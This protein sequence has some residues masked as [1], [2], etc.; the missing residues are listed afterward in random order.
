MFKYFWIKS[1][2]IQFLTFIRYEHVLPPQLRPIHAHTFIHSHF[3][4]QEEQEEVKKKYCVYRYKLMKALKT[5]GLENGAFVM[6]TAKREYVC[7]AEHQVFC[8]FGTR[9]HCGRMWT[10]THT[11]T[12]LF[13]I[14]LKVFRC[15]GSHYLRLLNG[16][17]QR[18]EESEREKRERGRGTQRVWVPERKKKRRI[19][20]LQLVRYGG[21]KG[22][23]R[24]K[25]TILWCWCKI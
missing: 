12:W 8:V 2:C 7:H 14:S 25:S 24:P 11:H 15:S 1:D 21:W 5:Y 19:L 22:L 9:Y 4:V 6:W 17:R 10:R 23:S 20:I 16:K 13:R 3:H 18:S